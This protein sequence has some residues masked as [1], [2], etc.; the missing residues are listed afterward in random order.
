MRFYSLDYR[1]RNPFADVLSQ[2]NKE[3]AGGN[4]NEENLNESLK[5]KSTQN[6]L[7]CFDNQ[8]DAVFMDCGHG[9]VCYECSL[10]LWKR[11]GDCFLCRNVRKF[12]D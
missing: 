4:E 6:C 8:P 1:D 5:E 10:D 12:I 9:G 11:T 2:V 3:T 7:I